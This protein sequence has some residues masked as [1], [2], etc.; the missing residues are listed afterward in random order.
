MEKY[1][2]IGVIAVLFILCMIL[3]IGFGRYLRKTRR[4]IADTPEPAQEKHPGND[5][6]LLE[7][8]EK[9]GTLYFDPVEAKH[10]SGKGQK[11]LE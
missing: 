3:S 10:N 9:T 7:E 5:T 1:I 6:H 4:E 2:L 8:F 11:G